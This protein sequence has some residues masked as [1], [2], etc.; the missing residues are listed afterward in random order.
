M[1]HWVHVERGTESVHV[2]T[3][4]TGTH[5]V[6]CDVQK[7]RAL[8][9]SDAGEYYCMAKNEAGQAKCSSQLMEVC[10]CF[11]SLISPCSL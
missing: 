1:Q 4:Q 8:K 11:I 10:E 6:F 7:F 9:K 3:I 5:T 2:E